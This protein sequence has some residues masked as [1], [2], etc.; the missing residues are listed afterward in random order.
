MVIV[1]KSSLCYQ[2]NG[3]NEKK[4]K[5]DP[6]NDHQQQQ[7]QHQIQRPQFYSIA[8]WV[9]LLLVLVVNKIKE[10]TITNTHSH[11]LKLQVC[12]L[13][14][15]WNRHNWYFFIIAFVDFELLSIGIILIIV[16]DVVVTG[17]LIL[18]CVWQW[19]F[20]RFKR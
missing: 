20:R 16:V 9:L 7:Q 17:L 14:L 10:P 8:E 13:N 18:T 5:W 15:T 4:K 1:V 11:M 6:H 3:R 19:W 2:K 12:V